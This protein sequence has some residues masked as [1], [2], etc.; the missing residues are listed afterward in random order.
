MKSTAFWHNRKVFLTGHTGFK[1]SWLCL[2]LNRLGARVT[3]YALAPPTTPSLFE[4]THVK[5]LVDSRIADVRDSGLL[6]RTLKEAQPEVVIHMAAQPLVRDSYRIP[7]ETYATNVMG[8]V[9]LL[10]AVRSCPSVKAVVNV[11]TDK[12]YEN[13]EWVWGYRENEPMGGFDPYSNSKACSELVTAAYRTSF[14]HPQHHVEHGVG[15]ASARAG[16]VIGGGDWA[17]DRLIPDCIRAL[18]AGETIP[19]RNPHAIRPWQHV[20]E[21]LSG[22]LALARHLYEHGCDYAEGWNFGPADEDAKPVEWIVKQ[23]CALWGDNAGYAIN[24]G[25]HPHEANYLKL[26]CS[27]ARMRLGWRPR[28]DLAN[29]LDSIVEWTQAYRAGSDLRT[30]CLEQIERYENQILE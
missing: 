13:R 27:K 11:T 24:E 2:W 10:E 25:D 9:H 7:V 21:P 19:I 23:M 1:G 22:Y 28:W 4:L 29:S 18:L 14:F 15:L 12:C 17:T 16:N 8:T 5:E 30:V 26:D 20:L 3:G 6:L